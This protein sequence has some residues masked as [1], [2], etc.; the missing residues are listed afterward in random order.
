MPSSQLLQTCGIQPWFLQEAETMVEIKEPVKPTTSAT[1]QQLEEKVCHCTQCPL[2]QTRTQTVFGSGSQQADLLIVG[3][4]PGA[5]EDK[6]GLPFVG[7]AG[8]LLTDMLQ[9]IHFARDDVYIVNILKCRP[10]NNRDPKAEEVNQCIG[11]LQQQIALLKPKLILAVGRIGAQNLL[12]RKEALSRLRGNIYHYDD[13]PVM[14]TY[15]PAYLLR[16]PQQ[17]KQAYKDLLRVKDFLTA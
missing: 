15:H 12:Q 13:I 9:A 11:Y 16:S 8:S 5:N 6:Q 10:P 1:W 4:A 2:H 17:K 3:E 14:V 7:R